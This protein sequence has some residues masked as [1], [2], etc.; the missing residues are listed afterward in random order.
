MHITEKWGTGILNVQV[1]IFLPFSVI[2]SIMSV[3]TGK[4]PEQKNKKHFYGGF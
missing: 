4:L 1:K 3:C 2:C